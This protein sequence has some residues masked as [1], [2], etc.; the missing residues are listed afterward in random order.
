[1]A[2]LF[3][4]LWNLKIM[5]DLRRNSNSENSGK[6][7]FP[8]FPHCGT[9]E[10]LPWDRQPR[11]RAFQHTAGPWNCLPHLRHLGLYSLQAFACSAQVPLKSESQC[12]QCWGPF[13]GR[14]SF[15]GGE[16]SSAFFLLGQNLVVVLERQLHHL[17]APSALLV[18][19]VRAIS[20]T[21][22]LPLLLLS[23]L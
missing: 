16:S 20:V 5:R 14:E 3:G 4:I 19:C 9:L 6:V 12:L 7:W 18:L 13:L 11:R 22:G 17:L 15:F 21:P 23:P 8:R 1:M 2:S 10:P